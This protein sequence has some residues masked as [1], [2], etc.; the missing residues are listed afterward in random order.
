[1]PT[2]QQIAD[3]LAD[4]VPTTA[5]LTGANVDGVNVQRNPAEARKDLTFF[6][7]RAARKAGTRPACFSVDLSNGTTDDA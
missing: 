2:D 7:R 1:M 4:A 5:G 3:A 6:E